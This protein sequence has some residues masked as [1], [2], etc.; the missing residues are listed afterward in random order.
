MDKKH[1][2]GT[3]NGWAMLCACPVNCMCDTA[4][5]KNGKC[6]CGKEVALVGTKGL[7]DGMMDILSCRT[8]PANAPVAWR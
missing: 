7:Y 3:R 4:G 1:L 5:V 2:L 8:T 6:A